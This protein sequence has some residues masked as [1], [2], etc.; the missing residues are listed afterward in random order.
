[1]PVDTLDA[2][3]IEELRDLYDAE[4][5]LTTAL[6][7]M[8]KAANDS[9]LK[10]GFEEHLEQTKGH[11]AR[12]EQAFELLE[13]KPRG[14]S[15]AAMKGLVEEASEHLKEKA[16]SDLKDAMMIASAQKVEHYEIAGYGTV[17]AIAEALGRDDVADLLEETL[18]E[19]KETDE[20]LTTVAERLMAGAGGEKTASAGST[21]RK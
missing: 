7:K 19:E 4:K 20:K 16:A 10:Q 3:L 2:L 5:Q 15:C 8:A 1:M 18:E 9:E 17:R 6:P 14:K 12:L 13:V 11:V 21:S